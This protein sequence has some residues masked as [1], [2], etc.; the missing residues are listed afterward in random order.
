MHTA[1]QVQLLEASIEEFGWTNPVLIGPNNEVLGGHG[2]I[3]AAERKG[4]TEVEC[5]R[6][7]HLTPVQMRAY[8]LT[9]NRIAEL[10]EWDY[11]KLEGEIEALKEFDFDIDLTGFGLD[12]LEE[13]FGE[14]GGAGMGDP[15]DA[16]EPPDEPTT[17][18]GDIYVMGKHRLICGDSTDADTVG[19]VLNGATPA[20]MVTD[21]PY[22]VEYDADWRNH[23]HRN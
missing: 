2:R 12:D 15:D 22:G 6:L 11:G 17:Q 5:K 23:A 1:A 21:P 10:A 8:R 20:L 4:L 16:G 9:D 13:M 18:P 14:E 7:A 19:R 3:E